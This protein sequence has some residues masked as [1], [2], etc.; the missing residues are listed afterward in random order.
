MRF[1]TLK[2]ELIRFWQFFFK[3]WGFITQKM[4]DISLWVTRLKFEGS[5]EE[6]H[7]DRKWRSCMCEWRKG[8]SFF[9]RID[10]S[11]KTCLSKLPGVSQD[12]PPGRFLAPVTCEKN[13]SKNT[14]KKRKKNMK[15]LLLIFLYLLLE[16]ITGSPDNHFIRFF[17]SNPFSR[18][19]WSVS[20]AGDVDGDSLTDRKSVV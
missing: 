7:V 18:G 5:G 9:S 4:K 6:T 1:V 10:W 8:D 12:L 17:V 14:E 13:S 11:S 20:S 19:G 3:R 16:I 15:G 2:F